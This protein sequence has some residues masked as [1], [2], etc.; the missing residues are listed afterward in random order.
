[1]SELITRIRQ[2]F[3]TGTYGPPCTEADLAEAEQALSKGLPDDLRNIYLSFNG[4][5]VRAR[6]PKLFPLL[7]RHANTSLV[8]STLLLWM[9]WRN[10]KVIAPSKLA[11]G[12][13]HVKLKHN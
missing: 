4:L 2:L 1:M 7:P 13:S 12:G 3:P 8:K 6:S 10:S 11:R 9:P 5:C